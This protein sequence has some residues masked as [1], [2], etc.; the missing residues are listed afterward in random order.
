[1]MDSVSE[2]RRE[3]TRKELDTNVNAAVKKKYWNDQIKG[4][5]GPCMITFSIPLT[6]PGLTITLVA[7][8]EDTTFKVY[9]TLH[10]VG[11]LFLAVAIILIILGCILRV[12][13]K[14]FIGPD[15]ERHLSPN[16]SMADL[17]SGDRSTQ[18]NRMQAVY[19]GDGRGPR[20]SPAPANHFNRQADLNP[21]VS[22]TIIKEFPKSELQSGKHSKNVVR[23]TSIDRN[24]SDHN[25]SC[26]GTGSETE[27]LTILSRTRKNQTNFR[28][29]RGSR[30]LMEMNST[31]KQTVSQLSNVRQGTLQNDLPLEDIHQWRS[32]KRKKRKPKESLDKG[33]MNCSSDYKEKQTGNKSVS[34]PKVRVDGPPHNDRLTIPS[35][36]RPDQGTSTG[37]DYMSG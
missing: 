35:G 20:V 37:D 2:L 6:I 26:E 19:T 21:P 23:K 5:L 17:R 14:P 24:A 16:P 15:I 1:M 10:I 18:T 31:D 25:S 27:S 30:H 32:S 36:E 13:W 29:P 28:S 11:I 33:L 22:S 3:F 12:L 7:F 8:S 34:I 9:G 4:M